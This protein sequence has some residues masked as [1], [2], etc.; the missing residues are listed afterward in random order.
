MYY[1]ALLSF[2]GSIYNLYVGDFIEAVWGLALAIGLAGVKFS[3]DV[4]G[5]EKFLLRICGPILITMFVTAGSAFVTE[6]LKE[7]E[8][9]AE[10]YVHLKE[11]SKIKEISKTTPE[12]TELIKDCMKDE[13]ISIVEYHDIQERYRQISKY[14]SK[15]ALRGE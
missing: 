9:S 8:I 11:I 7:I 14:K 12:T 15:K 5:G 2:F 13:K 4:A 3:W 6:I 10:K 1:L